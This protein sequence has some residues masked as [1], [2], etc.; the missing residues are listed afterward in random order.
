[1]LFAQSEFWIIWA[2]LCLI[3]FII[4]MTPALIASRRRHPQTLAITAL[5]ILFGWTMIGWLAAIVWAC[6]ATETTVRHI[7]S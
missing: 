2:V 4:Y 7:N 3:A 1:M 5:T 6:T